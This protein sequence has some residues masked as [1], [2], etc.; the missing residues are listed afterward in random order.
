MPSWNPT[1]VECKTIQP[2]DEHTDISYQVVMEPLLHDI[3]TNVAKCKGTFGVCYHLKFKQ[4]GWFFNHP[5]P[6]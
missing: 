6:V 2:I 5:D 1:L 3:Q 4:D